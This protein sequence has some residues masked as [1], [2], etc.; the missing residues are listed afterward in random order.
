M[1]G[2]RELYAKWNKTG[3]QQQKCTLCCDFSVDSKKEMLSKQSRKQTY[4]YCG[5]EGVL[6]HRYKFVVRCDKQV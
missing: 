4:N 6:D 5:K 3:K 1:V 2:F